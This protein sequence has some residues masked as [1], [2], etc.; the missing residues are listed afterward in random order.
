[1]SPESCWDSSPCLCCKGTQPERKAHPKAAYPQYLGL[2]LELQAA[3]S[4]TLVERSACCSALSHPLL[5]GPPSCP[6][7]PCLLSGPCALEGTREGT[8][9]S[10][11]LYGAVA[12]TPLWAVPCQAPWDQWGSWPEVPTSTVTPQTSPGAASALVLGLWD[13]PPWIGSS[14]SLPDHQG[15]AAC[16]RQVEVRAVGSTGHGSTLAHLLTPFLAMYVV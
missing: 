4:R 6:H 5:P 8:P 14:E 2:W 1:M 11:L 12:G 16:Q 9:C 3:M 7:L 15:E 10:Q 13:L